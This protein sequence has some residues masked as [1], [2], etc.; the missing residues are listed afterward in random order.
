M[1]PGSG[2]LA[3]CSIAALCLPVL[4]QDTTISATAAQPA[5]AAATSTNTV[6]LSDIRIVRLS[7]VRGKVEMD[8][9]IGRGFEEAF[10]NTPITGGT[11]L[12]T[13]VGLAEVEFEDNS[14]LRLTPDTEVEFTLLKR[15]ATGST[16]SNMKVVRGMVYASLANTKGNSF[17]I[18]AGESALQLEPSAHIRLTV[19]ASGS[20]VS[21]L[22]GTV[23]FTVGTSMMALK[24]KESVDFDIIGYK[25]PK[26]TKLEET[27]FDQWDKNG[28][29]YQ[30]QYSNLR[31]SNG[32]MSLYG[33]SDLNYYG[34]FVNMPGCGSLW[35]PYF[36]SA[37]WSPYD[38]GMWA[39]YPTVGYSWVSPYP[40][41]WLP[42]HSG[43]W[44][45]CG[46]AG[47]GWQPGGNFV[48]LQNLA[49]GGGVN[50]IPG[51]GG[52]AA[53]RSNG[54]P[55]APLPPRAGAPAM[56]PVNT[57]PIPASGASGQTFTFR[58]DSAGLGVPRDFGELRHMSSDVMHHGEAHTEIE[59]SVIG[60]SAGFA[61]RDMNGSNGNP[62]GNFNANRG[63][64]GREYSPGSRSI[65]TF[66]RAGGDRSNGM[67][68][69][70][71]M[72]NGMHN[73]MGN[74]MGNGAGQGASPEASPRGAW[75]RPEPGGSM[76]GAPM[77]RS[78]GAPATNPSAPSSGGGGGASQSTPGGGSRK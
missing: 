61:R 40:W 57:R 71:R 64:A 4:A 42:F 77:P 26:P 2:I 5:S 7:Q 51:G 41:G 39:Y 16:I 36:A 46:S 9:H 32:A 23:E 19:D 72:N 35:R 29:D 53:L 66:T 14:S 68:G 58:R 28:V 38:N 22:D 10:A 62:N 17:L 21:V 13:E 73:G 74:G 8:R 76:G 30:K 34:S 47:W 6:G 70:D 65:D 67:N 50:A 59:R 37:A 12:R 33:S 44:M 1:K 52:G 69:M 49:Y 18:T 3:L 31:T 11:R 24:K 20:N 75:Q 25:P 43:N 78:M 48:G 27:A 15:A 54:M 60:P 55:T 63:A 45:N 56:V